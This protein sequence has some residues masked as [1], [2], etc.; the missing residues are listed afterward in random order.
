MQVACCAFP[1]KHNFLV[2]NRLIAVSH[3]FSILYKTKLPFVLVFNKID[4]VS[5]EF[6]VQWMTDFEAF[7]QALKNDTSYMSSLMNSMSLVLDEFYQHLRVSKLLQSV[8]PQF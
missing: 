7:Q 8:Y 4:V 2:S 6:A 1:S 3:S 5:H